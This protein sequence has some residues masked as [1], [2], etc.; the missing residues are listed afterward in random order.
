MQGD[1][2]SRF[3]RN[4]TYSALP[5]MYI[6]LPARARAPPVIAAAVHMEMAVAPGRREALGSCHGISCSSIVGTLPHDH[7]AGSSMRPQMLGRGALDVSGRLP[8]CVCVAC[9]YM[10]VHPDGPHRW[11]IAWKDAAVHTSIMPWIAVYCRYRC[12]VTGTGPIETRQA[13]CQ[14]TTAHDGRQMRRGRGG[15]W[16]VGSSDPRDHWHY[17]IAAVHTGGGYSWS[18]R[19]VCML[20]HGTS[21]TVFRVLQ[22]L[23]VGL[24]SVAG[25]YR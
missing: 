9:V 21:I 11:W 23:T 20:S 15:S 17:S 19:V 1:I 13:D 8:T 4:P 7:A 14:H 24:V 10:Y 22:M 25:R 3:V 5:F 16:G 2:A 18:R 6:F 12:R